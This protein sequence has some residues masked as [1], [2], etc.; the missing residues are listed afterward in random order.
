MFKRKK[1][2]PYEP[3]LQEV[4][5]ALPVDAGTR[6]SDPEGRSQLQYANAEEHGPRRYGD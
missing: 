5:A 2:L 4:E 1:K 6:L 3:K